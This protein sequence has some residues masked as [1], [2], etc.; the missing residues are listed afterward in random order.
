MISSDGDDVVVD[1]KV[2]TSGV[3]MLSYIIMNHDHFKSFLHEK[4]IEILVC[5]IHLGQALSTN[6]KE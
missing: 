6:Q 4:E 1:C 5:S 2:R 3:E